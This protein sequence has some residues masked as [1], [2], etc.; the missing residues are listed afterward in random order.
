MAINIFKKPEVDNS[1]YGQNR[2]AVQGLTQLAGAILSPYTGG[3][4]IAAAQALTAGAE[5]AHQPKE[6]KIQQNNQKAAE[7]TNVPTEAAPDAMQRRY[8]EMQQQQQPVQQVAEANQALSS[9]PPEVQQ[10]YGPVL[11]NTYAKMTRA[12]V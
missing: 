1:F 4:S 2:G 6:Q 12:R 9:M 5:M 8:A 3:A 7:N 10:E 11:K